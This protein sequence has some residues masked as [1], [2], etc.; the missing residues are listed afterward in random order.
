MVRRRNSRDPM[1]GRPGDVVVQTIRDLA[2]QTDDRLA[3]MTHNVETREIVY[4]GQV[5]GHVV[6]GHSTNGTL[7]GRVVLDDGALPADVGIAA[8]GIDEGV[9][10]AVQAISPPATFAERVRASRARAFRVAPHG[11]DWGEDSAFPWAVLRGDRTLAVVLT[12]EEGEWQVQWR[13]VRASETAETYARYADANVNH[14]PKS[15]TAEI[16]GEGLVHGAEIYRSLEVGQP[17][18]LVRDPEN[19]VDPH[20]IVLKTIQSRAAGYVAREIAFHLARSIDRGDMWVAEVV[21]ARSLYR[22]MVKIS[23]V[24]QGR[25]KKKRRADP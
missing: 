7:T 18:V 2:I 9:R 15:V 16:R 6:E 13:E 4:R 23:R 11:D 8:L 1:L 25:R 5:V 10:N 19:E 20:A 17:L 3:S 14:I 22:A 21:R 24:A 12:E